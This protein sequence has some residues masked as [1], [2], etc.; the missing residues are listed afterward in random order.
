MPLEENTGTEPVKVDDPSKPEDVRKNAKGERVRPHTYW[1]HVKGH[2]SHRA[3]RNA[4]IDAMHYAI[5]KQLHKWPNPDLDPTHEITEA[6]FD[7]AIKEA[8]GCSMA[9]P[10]KEGK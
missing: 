1:A 8:K 2:A 7:A 3:S 6:E 9:T 5:A 10:P 4:I